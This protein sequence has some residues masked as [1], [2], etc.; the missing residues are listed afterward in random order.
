MGGWALTAPAFPDAITREQA[1]RLF[2]ALKPRVS[3]GYRSWPNIL[4]ESV[5]RAVE[6]RLADPKERERLIRQEEAAGFLLV[7]PLAGRL[8]E[9]EASGQTMSEFMPRLLYALNDQ[10]LLR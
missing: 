2:A 1:D 6:V 5:I 7:R 8:A 4:H 3:A 10:T 9:Y